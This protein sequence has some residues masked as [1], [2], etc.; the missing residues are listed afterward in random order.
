MKTATAADKSAVLAL[1]CEAFAKN[2]SVNYLV[3][4]DRKRSQRI[5][6]LMEYSFEVCSLFGTVWLS[7]DRKACALL[8]YP[9]LKK[10]TIRSIWLDAKL[11]FEAF[12]LKNVRKV[13]ERESLVQQ[14]HPAKEMAYLW[15][16]GV[17]PEYQHRGYGSRLLKE[18]IAEENLKALTICLE[19]SVL[20]NIAWYEHFGFEIYNRLEL[21]YTLFF[22]KREPDKC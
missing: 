22:L 3:K 11:V 1:L 19:T 6:A 15:F 16:I 17:H 5:K 10:T 8:L 12:G 9:H 20:G 21:D 2:P 7:D 13:M 18:I 4:Q 14:L